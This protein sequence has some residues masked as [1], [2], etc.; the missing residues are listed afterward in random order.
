MNSSASQEH[1]MYIPPIQQRNASMR[2]WMSD[3]SCSKEKM[4]HGHRQIFTPS[5]G[6]VCSSNAAY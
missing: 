6:I 4:K 1:D 5:M 3:I 2:C